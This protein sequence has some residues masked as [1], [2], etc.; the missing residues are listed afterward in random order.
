MRLRTKLLVSALI[1]RVEGEGGF[2]TV[3]ASGDADAGA[4]LILC[5]DRSGETFFVE[6]GITADGV[7]GLVR[8]GPVAPSDAE[9]LEAY[10]R[11]RRQQD[12]D[13][14]VLEL[15][16]PDAERFAAEILRA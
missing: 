6:R 3:L 14:W 5:V 15:M 16:I 1:R 11:R 2:A 4:M 12:P 7:A 10:W 8:S 13:L 9:A